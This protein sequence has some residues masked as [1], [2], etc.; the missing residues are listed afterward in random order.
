MKH[1]ILKKY[2]N[3]WFTLRDAK[4]IKNLKDIEIVELEKA[5]NELINPTFRVN[6]FCG[7]CVAEMVT[8]LY[9]ATN[10]DSQEEKFSDSPAVQEF[11]NSFAEDI[12]AEEIQQKEEVIGEVN[13]VE[14]V[15]KKRG[16][17]KK[18]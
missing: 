16:R 14:R 18:K 13:I 4:F 15:A 10:Y 3:H 8:I 6:K 9:K 12:K 17:K 7:S 5:Y 11:V 2:E 1:P